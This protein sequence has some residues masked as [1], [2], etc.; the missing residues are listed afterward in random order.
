[1][2]SIK[3]TLQRNAIIAG[4]II[5]SFLQGCASNS[6]WYPKSHSGQPV[7]NETYQLGESARRDLKEAR[8]CF[9][10]EEGAKGF[11]SGVWEG[12]KGGSKYV[13]TIPSGVRDSAEFAIGG[14]TNAVACLSERGYNP[15]DAPKSL[16]GGVDYVRQCLFRGLQHSKLDTVEDEIERKRRERTD[17]EDDKNR[18]IAGGLVQWTSRVGVAITSGYFGNKFLSKGNGSSEKIVDPVIEGVSGGRTGGIGGR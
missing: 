9:K 3:N 16:A 8:R 7:F 15:S 2:K 1:M 4:L 14:V 10:Y 6:Q 13:L 18:A 17:N 5:P 12:L 11:F